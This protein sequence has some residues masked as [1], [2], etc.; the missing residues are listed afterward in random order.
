MAS[1]KRRAWS[2]SHYLVLLSALVLA[3][4]FAFSQIQSD[5]FTPAASEVEAPKPSVAWI[6]R[7]VKEYP[8][9]SWLDALGSKSVEEVTFS[10]RTLGKE[11]PQFDRAL[12]SIYCMRTFLD[13][14]YEDYLEF[15]SHQPKDDQL[16]WRSF[17]KFQKHLHLTLS[18]YE[19]IE[20][21]RLRQLF[22]YAI[23]LN[24]VLQSE[25]IDQKLE[26][27]QIPIGSAHQTPQLALD[28]ADQIFPSYRDLQPEEKELVQKLCRLVQF[29]EITRLMGG[30]DLFASLRETGIITKDPLAFEMGFFIYTCNVAAELDQVNFKASLTYNEDIHQCLLAVKQACYLLKD[31]NELAAYNHYLEARAS[32]LGLDSGSPLHRVLTRIGAVLMLYKPDEGKVLKESL[33]RLPAEDLSL[34]VEEFN[35]TRK[36]LRYHIPS[37]LASV[38]VVLSNNPLLGESH[39][40]RL[41]QTVEI[42]LPLFAK[43][44][45]YQNESHHRPSNPP[46]NY[47]NIVQ[48]AESEP[49][50]LP[51]VFSVELEKVTTD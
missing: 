28:A 47:D 44:F 2:F 36:D 25:V 20:E 50:K 4:G 18:K 15:I 45:R 1:M 12:K 10:A 42:G 14:K 3:V 13:G 22:E 49:K 33:L 32:W 26:E 41:E 43:I 51:D 24:E 23:V 19:K 21:G 48:T 6:E 17:Q 29:D 31:E 46:L 40:N 39:Q 8:E 7:L 9:L 37:C 34:V 11:V 35:A 27:H 38:L 5:E 16:R 30:P